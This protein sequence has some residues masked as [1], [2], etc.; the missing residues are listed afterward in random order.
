MEL[1]R[2]QVLIGLTSSFYFLLYNHLMIHFIKVYER[3]VK[4]M[5]LLQNLSK[6]Q[7]RT[8][9]LRYLKDCKYFCLCIHACVDRNI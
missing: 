5:G 8:A 2:V 6:S 9:I 4:I 7:V 3:H 1:W